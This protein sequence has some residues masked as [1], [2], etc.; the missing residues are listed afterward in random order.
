MLG[1]KPYPFRGV[2]YPF[3]HQVETS[4]FVVDTP[5]CFV[6]DDI[7]T[8]KSWS[9]TWAIDCL[10]QN[11]HVRSVLIVAPLST[12]E[13]VWLRTFFHLDAA[14]DVVVLK[15]TATKRKFLLGRP[16]MNKVSIINPDALHII[17]EDIAK[18]D[19]YDMVVVDESAM[20]RNAKSRRVKALQAI[21]SKVNRVV[22]M[23]GSPCPE[24]P[25]DIWA[26]A[27]IVCPDRVPKYF[28]AFR[29]LTMKKIT[30]F[31]WI[32]TKDAQEI[33]AKLLKGFTIRHKREDCIDLPPSQ[34]LQYEVEMS[35][36]QKVTI[37]ALKKHCV[38]MLEDGAITAV[39][40]A[41]VRQKILQVTSGAVKYRD[42][43]GNDQVLDCDASGKYTAL[44]ELL[45][46]STQPI[47]IFCQFTAVIRQIQAWLADNKIAHAMIDGTVPGSQRLQ[48]FDDLQSGMTRVLIAHPSAMAHGITLTNSNII[49]WWAPIDSQEISEQANGRIVRPGQTRNTYF[50]YFTCSA[51]ESKI[52]N[53]LDSKQSM[54]GVL[55][56]YLQN[57]EN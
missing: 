13:I 15:G 27:K 8:G 30:E 38:A 4:N 49:C 56:D 48:H 29:D 24:A 52:L 3:R 37:E 14:L 1:G 57:A 46:F 17:A 34:V 19:E 36:L 31:K 28:G 40:E 43:D 53:N 6:L 11:R 12:M 39:N 47:I 32:A 20:F 18:L 44:A 33:V 26:T 25:T 5:K 22:M 21:C 55:L 41:V 23:T 16:G 50:V 10:M 54:Q 51:L 35:P 9:V 7:G 2:P 45:E 42:D